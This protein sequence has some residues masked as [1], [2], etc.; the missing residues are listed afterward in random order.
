MNYRRAISILALSMLFVLC[1]ALAASAQQLPPHPTAAAQ[2]TPAP[3]VAPAIP[4]YPDSSAGLEKLMKDMLKLE[5]RGDTSS[6]AP[7]LQSLVLPDP[8]GW[9]KTVFGGDLGS[10]L[11]SSYLRIKSDI[12]K[13]IDTELIRFASAKGTSATEVFPTC[14]GSPLPPAKFMALAMRRRPAQLYIVHLGRGKRQSTLGFF[15]YVNGGFRH[16][17]SLEFSSSAPDLR[18]LLGAGPV[19]R[20]SGNV[21]KANLLHWS[22]PIYPLDAKAN[23][24]NGTVV[25]RE[26]VAKDGTVRDV[27]YF[28]GPEL[29]AA[30]AMNAVRQWTYKPTKLNGVPVE[31]D[32]CVDIIFNLGN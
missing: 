2:Q 15:A 12:P 4:S 20:V 3:S 30:P 18:S 28:S 9:F 25:L 10:G 26:I 27:F 29:L 16:V 13:N 31:V 14:E 17:G 21:Q 6:L 5:K 1:V 22:S 7:Y 23:H 11:L 32:T 24:L 19:L 8:D